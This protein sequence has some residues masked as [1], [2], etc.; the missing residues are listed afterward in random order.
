M[1]PRRKT[2]ETAVADSP[3]D[4]PAVAPIDDYPEKGDDIRSAED[5]ARAERRYADTED[6]SGRTNPPP[7]ITAADVNEILATAT[8]L[9]DDLLFAAMQQIEEVNE[10]PVD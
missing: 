6:E 2:G 1:S 4:S 7:D 5:T 10:V 3:A 9:D 8:E